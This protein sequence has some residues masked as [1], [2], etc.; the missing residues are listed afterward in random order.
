MCAM[1]WTPVDVEAVDHRLSEVDSNSPVLKMSLRAL[2]AHPVRQRPAVTHSQVNAVQ[3]LTQEF[4]HFSEY[5][6]WLTESLRLSMVCHMPVMLPPHVLM[7]PPG[8]GKSFIIRKIVEALGLSYTGI[9][10]PDISAGFVLT[11]STSTWQSGQPGLIARSLEAGPVP[12]LVFDELDKCAGVSNSPIIPTLLSMLESSTA[13]EFRDECM[14]L[15]LDIQPLI[16]SF[17]AN[18]LEGIEPALLS[19]LEILSISL[20]NQ[21]DMPAIVLSV[22]R[23]LRKEDPRIA[24]IFAALSKDVAGHIGSMSPREVKQNL[25]RGYSRALKRHDGQKL[26]LRKSDLTCQSSNEPQKTQ[27]GIG[28]HAE[29]T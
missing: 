22:D 8:L 27:R 3:A 25:R 26:R 17:T 7:G 12:W 28:F 23:Q 5:L 10:L 1:T 19:R 6:E 29:I 2:R 20:P 15:S 14:E 24:M 4:P 9:N 11:G 16:F 13:G 21:R 18:T